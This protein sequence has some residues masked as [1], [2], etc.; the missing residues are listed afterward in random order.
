[1]ALPQTHIPEWAQVAEV[2]RSSLGL[3]RG[4]SKAGG[5]SCWDG[6]DHPFLLHTQRRM[7]L[8]VART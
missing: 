7:T 5:P 4:R 3:V 8:G 1:M 6:G 2:P